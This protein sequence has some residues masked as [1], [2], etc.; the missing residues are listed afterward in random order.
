MVQAAHMAIGLEFVWMS[1][2]HDRTGV[3]QTGS[4]CA[5][6]CKSMRGDVLHVTHCEIFLTHPMTH[7]HQARKEILF[8]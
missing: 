6:K 5:P 2:H 7:R 1:E 4:K 3:A 8:W